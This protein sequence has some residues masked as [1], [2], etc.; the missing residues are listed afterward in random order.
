MLVT[1]NSEITFKILDHSNF[2]KDAVIGEKTVSLGQVLHHY[3]G[4]IDNLELNMDL[5]MP[6]SKSINTKTAELVVVLN[7]LN[8]DM[9]QLQ[10]ATGGI[11]PLDPLK[12]ADAN[13]GAFSSSSV[14]ST[15]LYGG[16]RSRMRLRG[17]TQQQ[18]TQQ[19]TIPNGFNS[20]STT[21]STAASDTAIMEPGSSADMRNM[22]GTWT[23]PSV[24]INGAAAPSQRMFPHP[25]LSSNAMACS[26]PNIISPQAGP[27][28][29]MVQQEN[30][31]AGNPAPVSNIN[32]QQLQP[33]TQSVNNSDEQLPVGWEVRYDQFRRRYYVDHNTRS[34]YWEK[35]TPLPPGW[36][37]RRDPRGRVYY[38][39]HNTRTT[40]W[41]RPNSER[42]MHFAHWQNQRTHVIS[43][44]NQRFLYPQQ[45]GQPVACGTTAVQ[46]EDDGL[47]PM[48]AGW[49]KRLQPDNRVYFVNHKNRTTQWEDPRTQGQE[50][51][52]MNEGPLPPGWEIRYTA[53]GERFFVDHNTR[54]TTFED[55]RPG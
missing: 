16:I 27:S 31:G 17:A 20:S 34:T 51:S 47:G 18:A 46:E 15:V 24:Q 12:P 2:L 26:S 22:T 13:N 40:T 4:R 45:Q 25:T 8:I 21:S 6:N 52:L 35:P 42:L 49:E 14:G 7:G 33:A 48:P 54:K 28:V 50:V 10:G 41:Q 11:S 9:S 38:V 5:L 36:E 30:G 3:N 55:P 37:I 53:S 43:Q 29:G 44:G 19:S 23:T 39:D 32:D 1:P